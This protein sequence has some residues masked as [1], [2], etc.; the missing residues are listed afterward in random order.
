MNADAR[1]GR[2]EK[3]EARSESSEMRTGGQPPMNADGRRGGQMG[4][5]R[6]HGDAEIE[7]D[8][9]RQKLEARSERAERRQK[10]KAKRHK[11][12]RGDG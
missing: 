3:L 2:S 5:T 11:P 1:S 12:R 4:Q 9:R 10:A 6:R 8:G 7:P